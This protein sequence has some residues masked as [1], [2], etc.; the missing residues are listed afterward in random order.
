[1]IF[2]MLLALCATAMLPVVFIAALNA[3]A[4]AHPRSPVE[5]LK[6]FGRPLAT[7]LARAVARLRQ[8]ACRAK[9]ST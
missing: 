7:D 1:M 4:E 5:T 8:L 2:S 9:P 3:S 6:A